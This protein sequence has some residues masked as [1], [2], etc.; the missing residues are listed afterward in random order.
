MSAAK[1]RLWDANQRPS[2]CVWYASQGRNPRQ[3][4]RVYKDRN[5]DGGIQMARRVLMMVAGIALAV[6]LIGVRAADSTT[7]VDASVPPD[8]RFAV[9]D[10][11]SELDT[12]T[13]V[14]HWSSGTILHVH[15]VNPERLRRSLDGRLATVLEPSPVWLVSRC[16]D[17]QP[18]KEVLFA[19]VGGGQV[20]LVQEEGYG[21]VDSRLEA[22]KAA[23][24]GLGDVQPFLVKFEADY[25]LA[26]VVRGREYVAPVTTQ[27]ETWATR[28]SG[29][30]WP[31]SELVNYMQ[32]RQQLSETAGVPI[33]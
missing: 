7:S 28:G 21:A 31:G 9:T 13:G 23:L 29:G 32:R 11:V 27:P 12:P 33:R 30:L 18:E 2:V 5:E 4:G 16:K 17:G 20:Q 6:A 25:F 10:L 24:A 1:G 15:Y 19:K 26:A 14:V 3:F 8:V 22:F